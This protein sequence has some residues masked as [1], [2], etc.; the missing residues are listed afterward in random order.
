MLIFD[1]VSLN[2][3]GREV[4]SDISFKIGKGEFVALIG[5]NGA[6]KT[7]LSKLC[8]GLL[9]PTS[10]VVNVRG[11]DTKRTKTSEIAKFTGFLFQNPDRQICQN[12]VRD[13]IA[14]GLRCIMDDETEIGRRAEATIER[15][16]FDGGATP[17]TLSRG[18]R[19]IL[20]LASLLAAGPELLILDEPTTGLDYRE[21]MKVM[22]CVEEEVRTGT[23][24]LMVTHDM[25]IVQ[26]F[27]RRV[28]VLNGGILLDDAPVRKIMKDVKLLD[29]A[30]LLPA[31]IA[32]LALRLGA[33]YED[34]FT[35]NEMAAMIEARAGAK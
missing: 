19:Q 33:E 27:A 4:I 5:A 18:E 2:I 30:S 31:Q 15:F 10:G 34:V 35:V 9:K 7:S 20:A 32:G 26:D 22:E 1:G 13:E 21:C 29:R 3:E 24:I 25:E 12:C 17:F 23:T 14:F 28:L 6:G 16:G 8:N 11:M